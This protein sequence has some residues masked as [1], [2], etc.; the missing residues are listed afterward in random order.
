MLHHPS[1][2]TMGVAK[3]RTRSSPCSHR[4]MRAFPV[5]PF[6]GGR[7]GR[8]IGEPRGWWW[9]IL[10]GRRYQCVMFR[11]HAVRGDLEAGKFEN[12]FTREW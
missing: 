4:R 5:P 7:E 1:T 2:S 3:L 12:D 11:L 9:E 8:S 10:R 6:P